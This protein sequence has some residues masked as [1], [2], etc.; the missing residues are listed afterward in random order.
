MGASDCRLLELPTVAAPEGDLTFAEARK[1]VPFPIERVFYVY[2]VPAGA[3]RGG[4]AHRALEEAVFCLAGRL[5]AVVD[6][7]AERRS[8]SLTDPR[9]GLYLPP[10]V[11][12]D[13]SF[14]QPGTIY[15]AFASAHYDESDYFRDHASFLEAAGVTGG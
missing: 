8:F 4:H 2:D 9:L 3:Q 12:H 7:G 6:D 14:P 11:W 1:H 15:V 13:L 10:M 5:D